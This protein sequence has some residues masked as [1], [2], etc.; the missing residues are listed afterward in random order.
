MRIAE[1]GT[2]IRINQS[3]GV[4]RTA[5]SA[6]IWQTSD[7]ITITPAW[8]WPARKK[9]WRSGLSMY[10]LPLF[11]KEVSKKISTVLNRRHGNEDDPRHHSG[12]ASHRLSLD[13]LRRDPSSMS[14]AQQRSLNRADMFGHRNSNQWSLNDDALEK[15]RRGNFHMAE[16]LDSSPSLWWQGIPLRKCGSRTRAYWRGC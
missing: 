9:F 12:F 5:A 2:L 6:S 4:G 8:A 10:P 16:Y 3:I 11:I 13:S 7:R 14:R 15:A 1:S